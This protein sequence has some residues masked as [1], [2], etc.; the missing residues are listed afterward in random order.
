MVAAYHKNSKCTEMITLA[1]DGGNVPL[2]HVAPCTIPVSF[3]AFEEDRTQSIYTLQYIII[4]TSEILCIVIVL[5]LQHFGPRR[6]IVVIEIAIIE[7]K[8][9]ISIVVHTLV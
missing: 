3:T 8:H 7:S 6:H 9:Q 5:Y 2:C 1:D 4:L